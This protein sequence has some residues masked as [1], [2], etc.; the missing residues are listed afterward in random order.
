MRRAKTA[1]LIAALLAFSACDSLSPA[2]DDA[3]F[4]EEF[5]FNEPVSFAV[6]FHGVTDM[7]SNIIESPNAHAVAR[8]V[9]SGHAAVVPY[10]SAPWFGF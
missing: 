4:L 3:P 9:A 2:P 6:D 8:M 1:A 10:G 7:G 5:G